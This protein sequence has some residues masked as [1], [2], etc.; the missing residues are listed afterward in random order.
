MAIRLA[1]MPG[2][3]PVAGK[4]GNK[5]GARRTPCGHGHTHASKAEAGWCDRLHLMQRGGLIRNLE[6]QPRFH[7]AGPDGRQ[8][9][10]EGRPVRYTAD[11]RFDEL[12]KDGGWHSVVADV[13]GRYRDDSWRLRRA[14]F[15]HFNPDVELREVS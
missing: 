12:R 7:F 5:F 3:E 11:F 1:H 10:D 4:R 9:T 14:F 13:K 6:Q 8:V 2:E 15:R